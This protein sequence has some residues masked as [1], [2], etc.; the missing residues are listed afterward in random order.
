MVGCVPSSIGRCPNMLGLC[1]CNSVAICYS[2]HPFS[3]LCEKLVMRLPLKKL[4]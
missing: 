4:R 2:R 1:D 3:I